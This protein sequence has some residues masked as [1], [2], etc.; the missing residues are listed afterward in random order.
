MLGWSDAVLGEPVVV[1]TQVTNTRSLA[2]AGRLGFTEVARFEEFGAEQWFGLTTSG[3]TPRD[4]GRRDADRPRRRGGVLPLP[5]ADGGARPGPLDADY[6]AAVAHSEPWVVERHDEVVGYVLL[7]PEPDGML[8][9]NV[10]VL[11]SHHGQGIGRA[12]L[13]LA[14]GRAR[15]LG[16]DRIRLYTHVTMV[17][18]Q[19]LYERLGY[20]ETH[21][22]SDDGLA[23]VFYEK[24][25]R[26]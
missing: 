1:C 17:E 16:L 26:S 3:H 25:L 7:V 19:R 24:P 5:G 22:G 9:D 15:A 13:A 6:A 14:E 12:L 23:R 8:L 21:R 2:L 11:P 10:A 18:N 20:V 4:A